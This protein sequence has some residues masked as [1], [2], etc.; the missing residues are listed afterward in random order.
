MLRC[1]KHYNAYLNIK[2]CIFLERS[3]FTDHMINHMPTNVALCIPRGGSTGS[4]GRNEPI[5]CAHTFVY[6]YMGALVSLLYPSC[7]ATKV[8]CTCSSPY[9]ML[10][11]APFMNNFLGYNLADLIDLGQ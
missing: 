11:R 2:L 6:K 7:F 9:L 1:L 8:T 3:I 4:K 10:V 5:M